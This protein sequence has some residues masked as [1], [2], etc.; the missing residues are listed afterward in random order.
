MYLA[1]LESWRCLLALVEGPHQ[2]AESE[3]IT[4]MGGRWTWVQVTTLLPQC[5]AVGLGLIALAS[6]SL[7]SLNCSVGPVLWIVGRF[8]GLVYTTNLS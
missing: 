7:S 4:T 6:L 2:Q 3:V 1:S 5:L 8:S